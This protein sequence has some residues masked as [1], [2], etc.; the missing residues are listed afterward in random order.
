MLYLRR[1]P[2]SW[3][4]DGS[5]DIRVRYV[6]PTLQI[7]DIPRPL[8]NGDLKSQADPKERDFLFPSPFDS[9]DH[10][11][12]TALSEPAR[13]DNAPTCYQPLVPAQIGRPTSPS[14]PPAR[15]RD[16]A[17][18]CWPLLVA[19]DRT[20]QPTG[21]V[22]STQTGNGELT[23]STS[24]RSHRIEACSSA[25]TTLIYESCSEVYFPTRTM[26]TESNS[27]SCLDTLSISAVS[28]HV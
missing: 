24:F 12:G 20:N 14:I 1:A 2:R 4:L 13:Y 17:Q 7:T 5:A 18:D 22:R 19:P 9:S 21:T 11:L 3:H 10:A 26:D 16:T 25:L 6:E 27:R 15:H 23:C 28:K 8:D